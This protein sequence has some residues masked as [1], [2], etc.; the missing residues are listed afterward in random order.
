MRKAKSKLSTASEPEPETGPWALVKEAKPSEAQV[1]PEAEPEPSG[2]Q[3][4]LSSEPETDL[5]I[6][7]NEAKPEPED[8]VAP[9]TREPEPI[10]AQ[11]ALSKEPETDLGIVVN[12]A[13][14]E[15]SKAQVAPSSEPQYG[16]ETPHLYS[17]EC[18]VRGF[19]RFM[20]D[21]LYAGNYDLYRE[22][23]RRAWLGRLTPPDWFHLYYLGF[24]KEMPKGL[25]YKGEPRPAEGSRY[26][27][28]YSA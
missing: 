25:A 22:M 2:V 18:D 28:L 1:A 26:A 14:P 3:I 15:P 8:A 4:A 23:H 11:V 5:R 13:K 20:S 21:P 10:G 16:R 19:F 17:Q 9:T 12:E 24:A 7:V 27:D 6:V